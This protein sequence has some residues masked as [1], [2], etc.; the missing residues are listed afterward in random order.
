MH[1]SYKLDIKKWQARSEEEKLICARRKAKIQ[2]ILW[3]EL[4]LKED[5]PKPGGSGS[6]NDGN[7]AR[8]T[9]Q[10]PE[11]FAECL[12]LNPTLIRNF[13]TI[14]IAISCHLPID[15]EKFEE[16]CDSTNDLYVQ[17]YPWYY[18]CATLHII[19]MHGGDIIKTSALPVGM[20]PEEASESRNKDYKN[21]RRSHSRQFSREAT[22]EDVFLRSMDTSNPQ[23]ST[24]SLRTRLNKKKKLP[25]PAEIIALLK[26]P[27]IGDDSYN[28]KHVYETT[29]TE[30]GDDNDDTNDC[31]GLNRFFAQLD[32]L[33]IET[34]D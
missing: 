9:F 25:L 31:T 8:R 12:G 14:L 33:E 19:L 5:K 2:E 32:T 17:H 7:T 28:D 3:D 23:I 4:G 24:L 18:R 27:E 22:L 16:L 13:S 11:L 20:L 26:L 34:E 15:P 21:F 29:P 10:K 6:T 30:D 1:I